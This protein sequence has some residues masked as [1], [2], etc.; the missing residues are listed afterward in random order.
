MECER[1]VEWENSLGMPSYSKCGR[2]V[3]YHAKYKDGMKGNINEENVCGIHINS[4]KKWSK[5][6]MKILNYDTELIITDL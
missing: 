1:M 2:K 6:L 4:L 3:K 5:R